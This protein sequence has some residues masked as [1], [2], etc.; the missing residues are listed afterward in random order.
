MTRSYIQSAPLLVFTKIYKTSTLKNQTG[1]CIGNSLNFIREADISNL[2]RI[3]FTFLYI[4]SVSRFFKQITGE[5]FKRP[6]LVP[7]K[8]IHIHYSWLSSMN[9]FYE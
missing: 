1:T 7:F 2:A 3:L 9:N 4:S 6:L 5:F 8:S